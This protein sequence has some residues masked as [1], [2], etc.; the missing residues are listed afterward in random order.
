M[1]L[2][3]GSGLKQRPGRLVAVAVFAGAAAD[4][5]QARLTTPRTGGG[6]RP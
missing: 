3:S 4:R 6:G 5:R 1:V 2:W